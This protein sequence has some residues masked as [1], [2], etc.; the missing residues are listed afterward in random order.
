MKKIL[1]LLACGA[2][3]L[4][5]W[6]QQVS[7]QELA[8]PEQEGASEPEDG[9]ERINVTGSRIRQMDLEGASPVKVI[10]R[11]EIENSSAHTVGGILQSSTFVPYGGDASRIDVRGMGSN[12]T[13][14]LVNGRRLPK[15]GGSYGDRSTNVNAIPTSVVERI[16]VLS[17]GA[18]AVYGSEALASV[19]NII[20]RKNLDGV[21]VSI[22]PR[23]GSVR[24]REFVNGSVSWGKNFSGGNVST[25][26]DVDYSAGGHTR[27]VD[28][29]HPRVLRRERYSDNYQLEG[30]TPRKTA[31][32]TCQDVN[33]IGECAWYHGDVN[34]SSESYKISNYTEFNRYLGRG[35]HFNGDFIGRYSEGGSY[36]P[37]YMRLTLLP[38]EIPPNSPAWVQGGRVRFT[39]RLGGYEALNTASVY[40]LGSN[41]GLSGDF[42]EGDWMWSLNNNFSGYSESET[43]GNRVLIEES[44]KVFAEDRYNPFVGEGFSKVAGE[45]LYDATSSTEYYLN[46]LNFNVDGPVYEGQKVSLAMA[47]GLEL[48]Y[49]KYREIGDPEASRGNVADLQGANSSGSR[50]HR[51][52]Y[53]E[54]GANYSSW[55]ESQLALRMERYSD[56]GSTLN[57]KLAVRV[58]PWEPVVF[59]AS[60]G[61]GFKAPE[62]SESRGGQDLVGYLTLT[63]DE[64]CE[65]QKKKSKEVAGET[66]D[67]REARIAPYCNPKSYRA[68]VVSN[69][70]IEEETSLSYNVG[71][72]VEPMRNVTVKLDYW[73][74]QV[75]DV[76][77][78]PPIQHVLK[79]RSEGKDVD[80][81]SYGIME[82]VRDAD[83]P[84]EGKTDPN[85][86]E[87]R[88]L[89]V[90]NI[91]TSVTRGLDMGIDYRFGPKNSLRLDYSLMLDDYYV[92]DSQ[93]DSSL[94]DYGVPRYRY[95]LIWDYNNILGS[96]HHLRLER[97]TVG[98]YK[99]YYEDGIIPAHSQYNVAWRW[100]LSPKKGELVFKANNLFN[101]HPEY[102]R[103]QDVYFDT[104][105]YSGQSSYSVQ[106]KVTF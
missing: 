29:V 21:S 55:L 103:T 93:K 96:N 83:P 78:I 87:I 31:F 48:G 50:T 30:V 70:Q 9:L 44:K 1:L 46:V 67:A 91:G 45:V 100:N 34:R 98:R 49:H 72:V 80:L 24:D 68:E 86:D 65:N 35:I 81:A 10:S 17:D 85:I 22:K 54:L 102:D 66:K 52:V 75:E 74:Y 28:Y 15:T 14:V 43:Y 19:I 79:M 38:N 37:A 90:S 89:V 57:P 33:D 101:L 27:D 5:V 63:D 62:L 71:V 2:L 60:V 105:L 25:S 76:I 12:R 64:E 23:K 73:D 42:S 39:H 11:E 4:S 95:K 3:S 51:A 99:N 6:A 97:E 47:A 94:G 77:G 82:I 18:S 84:V 56:F 26:F 106:Y 32:P 88:S 69:P 92:L 40:N 13:L 8:P 7:S 36:A 61:T 58:K 104:S 41:L 53:A 59:R 16:E 20:T